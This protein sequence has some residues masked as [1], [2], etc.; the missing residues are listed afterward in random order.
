MLKRLF[1]LALILTTTNACTRTVY[2]HE[3]LPVYPRPTLPKLA[4]AELS[5]LPDGVYARLARRDHE[6]RKH[7]EKLEVVI[8]STHGE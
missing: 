8:K 7:V 2:V 6:W 5:C 3:E 4:D 1:A